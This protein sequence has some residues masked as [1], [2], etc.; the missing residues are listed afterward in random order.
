MIQMHFR[1]QVAILYAEELIVITLFIGKKLNCHLV[2]LW[3]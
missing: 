1:Y 3:I 2:V